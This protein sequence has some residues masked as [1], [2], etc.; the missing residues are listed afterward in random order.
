MISIDL[1]EKTALV[2]GATGQLGRVMARTLA[3]AGADIILHYHQNKKQNR[4]FWDR[5]CSVQSLFIVLVFRS[6]EL[7]ERH[8]RK[9]DED[10]NT[11]NAEHT[12][13]H[14]RESL[15]E[16]FNISHYKFLLM[17]G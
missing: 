14:N 8:N 1:S 9:D 3:E 10:V 7:I 4:S 2:T 6:G 12:H 13:T 15:H 16:Y 17:P 11:E 5:F